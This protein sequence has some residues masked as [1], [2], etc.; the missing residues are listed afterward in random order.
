MR[1]EQSADESSHLSD[2]EV[3]VAS[4]AEP[5]P[6]SPLRIESSASKTSWAQSK[7]PRNFQRSLESLPS[8]RRRIVP[9]STKVTSTFRHEDGTYGDYVGVIISYRSD[10]SR[11]EVLFTNS[12]VVMK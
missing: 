9:I 5:L 12:F 3:V 10:I 6:A 11:Y 7:A 4:I 2:S 8:K 1:E